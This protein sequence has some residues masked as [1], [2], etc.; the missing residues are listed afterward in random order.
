ML[1]PKLPLG[2]NVT[3]SIAVNWQDKAVFSFILDAQLCIK[4]ACLDLE[5]AVWT[6]Q[7]TENTS[8]EMHWAYESPA[9][10][11]KIERLHLKAAIALSDGTI[12]VLGRGRLDGMVEQIS[13]LVFY[14]SVVK[15]NDEYVL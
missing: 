11:H 13:G 9:S 12:A 8:G 14:F 5:Q 2:H 6:E 1:S 3:T 7:D 15:E 4:S 10:E